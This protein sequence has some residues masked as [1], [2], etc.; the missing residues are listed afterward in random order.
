MIHPNSTSFAE[1]LLTTNL[2][3]AS[4]VEYLQRLLS[5]AYLCWASFVDLS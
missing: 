1:Y 4:F 5:T 3:G 2:D